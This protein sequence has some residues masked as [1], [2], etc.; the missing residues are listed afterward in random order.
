MLRKWGYELQLLSAWFTHMHAWGF[1]IENTS[2]VGSLATSTVG[3]LATFAKFNEANRL[4]ASACCRIGG[5]HINQ[6]DIKYVGHI[7]GRL[8]GQISRKLFGDFG[9]TLVIHIMICCYC[10]WMDLVID[11]FGQNFSLQI[12]VFNRF[13]VIRSGIGVITVPCC[14][15]LQ[16]S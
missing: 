2:T 12:R 6:S 1:T 9:R 11:W 3:P 8:V 13:E 10:K 4:S 7:R 15:T 16:R 14:Q 5:R